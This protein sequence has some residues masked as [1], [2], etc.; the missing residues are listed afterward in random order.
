ME[1]GVYAAST[2]KNERFRISTTQWIPSVKR[3]ESRSPQF[4]ESAST[5]GKVSGRRFRT[6]GDLIEHDRIAAGLI[7]VHLSFERFCSENLIN[8][9]V[10][11]RDDEEIPVR[12]GVNVRADAEP[13]A[14]EQAF[15]FGDVELGEV[16]RDAIFQ[17]RIV[18]RNLAAVP[19]EVE[20]KQG[21]ALE[22]IPRRT[23]DEVA[24]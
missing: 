21:A 16:I 9:A 6:P 2:W 7:C 22:K 19:G 3:H 20:T 4:L 11:K 13:G 17:P 23:D 24:L 12:P 1:R 15:A 10:R 8:G 14:E 18:H 5:D